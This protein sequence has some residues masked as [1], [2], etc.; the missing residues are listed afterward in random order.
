MQALVGAVALVWL[1]LALLAF[2]M[3]GLLRQVPDVNRPH[4]SSPRERHRGTIPAADPGFGPLAGG[5]QPGRD[6]TTD[7]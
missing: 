7:R 5:G 1:A 4:P 3:A 6:S 2:A